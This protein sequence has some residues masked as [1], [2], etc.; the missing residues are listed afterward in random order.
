MYL[1]LNDNIIKA[2]P[3]RII[4][5]IREI[6]PSIIFGHGSGPRQCHCACDKNQDKG[7]FCGEKGAAEQSLSILEIMLIWFTVK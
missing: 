4:D 5:R 7:H 3:V 2:V 6:S 1:T